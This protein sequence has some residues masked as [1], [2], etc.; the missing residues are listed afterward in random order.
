MGEQVGRIEAPEWFPA[1]Y[2][3]ALESGSYDEGR[4]LAA[5]KVAQRAIL[6]DI[7]GEIRKMLLDEKWAHHTGIRALRQVH[8]AL[9]D[10]T[11]ESE[12]GGG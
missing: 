6:E 4:V 7:Q 10:W 12:A 3:A 1:A 8:I 11:F 9:R 5:C 2:Q